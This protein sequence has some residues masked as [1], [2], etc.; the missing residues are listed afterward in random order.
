MHRLTLVGALA[1]SVLVGFLVL[2]APTSALTPITVTTIDD[3]IADDGLCSLREAVIAANTDSS[4]GGCPA[5]SGADQIGFDPTLPLPSVFLLSNTGANE[6]A[7]LTGDLDVQGMLTIN[8]LGVDNTIVDGLD[9]DRVFQILPGARVTINGIKGNAED[10]APLLGAVENDEPHSLRIGSF[11]T[12]NDSR[13]F[14]GDIDEFRISDIVRSDAWVLTSYNN[15][16]HPGDVDAPGFYTL[17]GEE[18]TW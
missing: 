4:V 3:V 17:G 2:V 14:E 7:A 8:G 15:Q 6:D 10:F 11:S 5:G 1:L 12:G 13:G 16:S 9:A 18:P